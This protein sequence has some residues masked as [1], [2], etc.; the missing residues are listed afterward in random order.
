MT[1][2]RKVAR[3]SWGELPLTSCNR[4][5][6]L[7]AVLLGVSWIALLY[8]CDDLSFSSKRSLCSSQAAAFLSETEEHQ[9]VPL[10]LGRGEEAKGVK[11]QFSPGSWWAQVRGQQCPREQGWEEGRMVRMKSSVLTGCQNLLFRWQR[12]GVLAADEGDAPSFSQ[13]FLGSS[14]WCHHAYRFC[15]F[16]SRFGFVVLRRPDCFIVPCVTLRVCEGW[17]C[18]FCSAVAL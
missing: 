12:G 4:E 15:M 9:A 16:P 2:S 18:L 6:M 11:Q 17:L 8:F 7:A 13:A 5:E 1:T 14:L 3:G 10:G